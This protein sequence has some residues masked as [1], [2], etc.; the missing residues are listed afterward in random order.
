M[1]HS[2]PGVPTRP[3]TC[4]SRVWSWVPIPPQ[5]TPHH[6]GHHGP[7]LHTNGYTR[8]QSPYVCRA[9]PV[10]LLQHGPPYLTFVIST[11]GP[12]GSLPAAAASVLHRV[13]LNP[14]GGAEVVEVLADRHIRDV[15]V[16]LVHLTAGANDRVLLGEP[17]QVDAAS[18][19][20]PRG[21]T[22]LHIT[23]ARSVTVRNPQFS[24]SEHRYA[25]APVVARHR[26]FPPRESNAPTPRLQTYPGLPRHRPRP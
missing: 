24:S 25:C 20:A 18:L 9:I 7:A 14:D 4:W 23:K 26:D 15:D 5:C 8:G 13:G 3:D 16:R 21:R 6:T 12:A 10:A 17:T 19:V 1:T 22:S 11:P 2:S